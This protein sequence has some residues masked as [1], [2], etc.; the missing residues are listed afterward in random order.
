[1]TFEEKYSFAIK[2]L[3]NTKIWKSNYNPPITRLLH[4]LGVKVPLPHYNSFISNAVYIGCFMGL[5]WGSF[6]YLFTWR[7][8][9]LSIV[10]MFLSSL[11]FGIFVGT[12]MSTYYYYDAK[13]Y[14][15]TP[16]KKIN[17]L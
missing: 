2:E 17:N 8:Q 11:F 12:C 13:K 7:T 14:K 3:Q 10:T 5:F 9:E 16:W 15:L 4:K 1:M 6:M